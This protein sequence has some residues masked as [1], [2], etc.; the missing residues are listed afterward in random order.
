MQ[1]ISTIIYRFFVISAV[2]LLSCSSPRRNSDLKFTNAKFPNCPGCNFLDYGDDEEF[3]KSTIKAYHAAKSEEAK[4]YFVNDLYLKANVLET[5][6]EYDRVVKY[7]RA[8]LNLD[9]ENL[10]LLKKFSLALIR[11]GKLKPAIDSLGRAY[12]VADDQEDKVNLGLLMGSLYESLDKRLE[13]L[14][15]YQKVL[16]DDPTN[17]ES[18]I[19]VSKIEQKTNIKLAINKLKQCHARSKDGKAD[20]SFQLGRVYLD[21][22]DLASSEKYFKRAYK[23]DSTKSKAL[24][25]LAVIYEELG[26]GEITLN[27]FKRHL[28]QNPEDYLILG[29]V[30]DYYISKSDFKK[31]LPYL[32]KMT[33]LNPRELTIRFKLSYL[34]RE[35]KAYRKAIGTL[36][37]IV[38]LGGD[39]DKAFYFLSDINFAINQPQIAMIYLERIQP[40][41]HFYYDSTLKLVSTLKKLYQGTSGKKSEEY[42]E[43]Y[44][45]TLKERKENIEPKSDLYFELAISEA[46]YWENKARLGRSLASLEEVQ[47]HEKFS[48]NHKYFLA[49]LYEKKSNYDKS[50]DIILKLLEEN[51]ENYHALNFIG[52]SHL[53]REG[54]DLSVAHKYLSRALDLSPDDGHVL[55]SMGWYWFKKGNFEESLRFLLQARERLPQD[56]TI[57]KHVGLAYFRLKNPN[58]ASK[59]FKKALTLTR[60]LSLIEELKGFI[61]NIK[62]DTDRLPA[63]ID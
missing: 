58:L 43:R 32:E 60:D 15:I 53:E 7:Q 48:E 25:A 39:S 22:S 4:S 36:E 27:L 18:C 2:I 13:A 40:D 17:A 23:E 33:D 61:S 34:Y 51:P 9:P 11:V 8:L 30:L 50:D 19:R 47:A 46:L 62:V 42:E 56:P 35:V 31:A 45:K 5:Q 26:K 37:E 63:S 59:F 3:L 16:A 21:M 1:V 54:G 44:L 6:L 49:S 24:A 55:D 52:Y 57:N 28:K 41:S 10:F 29:R 12:E 20:L 14:A 38:A